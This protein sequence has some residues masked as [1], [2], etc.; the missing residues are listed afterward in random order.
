MVTTPSE[1]LSA[2]TL[3]DQTYRAVRAA[4]ATGKLTPGQRVTERGLAEEFAVSPTPVREAIRRLQQDGLLERTGPRTVKVSFISETAIRDL[5]EVEISLRGMIARFAAERATEEQLDRLDAI[6]DDADDLLILIR[7]R[8]SEGTPHDRHVHQ[9]LDTMQRFNEAVE[10][11]VGNPVLLRLVEQ[12]RVFS[13]SGRRAR[14]L[15]LLAANDEF[16]MDR[17]QNHRRLV[18]ALRDRDPAAAEKIATDRARAGMS[19]LLEAPG[20]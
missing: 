1:D 17:Y 4:I 11:C 19:D 5:A 13:P 12:A 8:R 14:L 20:S 16:G 3:A 15:E 9:L 7:Q 2:E 10:D 6:L 18:R